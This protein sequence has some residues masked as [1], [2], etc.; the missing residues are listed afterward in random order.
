M[1]LLLKL[2]THIVRVWKY[3]IREIPDPDPSTPQDGGDSEESGE[4]PEQA[5]HK[6]RF[7]W[8]YE[9]GHGEDTE[10][11]RSPVM[12]DGDQFFEYQFNR[13]VL[14][15]LSPLLA[16]AGL[17]FEITVKGQSDV[18]LKERVERANALAV[19]SELPAIFVSIHAN[20]LGKGHK[21]ENNAR[22]VEVWHSK[23]SLKGKYIASVFQRHIVNETGMIDRK[24]KEKPKGEKDFFVLR[25]TTMPAV[26][27]ENGFFTHEDE[28]QDL[29][30]PSFQKQIA[31]AHFKA[32]MEIE[33][34]GVI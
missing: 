11:K 18:E 16:E 9:P 33:R 14:H 23:N 31:I 1:K 21:W 22:G 28:V 13:A 27:T 2:I 17:A 19:N 4:N 10:G 5:K 25:F 7:F 20:A 15:M 6:P 24:I 32:M 3:L 29:M 30:D 8:I 34:T 26:L 12:E